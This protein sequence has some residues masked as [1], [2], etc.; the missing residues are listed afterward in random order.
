MAQLKHPRRE[1]SSGIRRCSVLVAACAALFFPTHAAV[2][3][4]A[5]LSRLDK[6]CVAAIASG[7]RNLAKRLGR[8]LLEAT[9]KSPSEAGLTE[10]T[11]VMFDHANRRLPWRLTCVFRANPLGSVPYLAEA[12]DSLDFCDCVALVFDRDM[13]VKARAVIRRVWSASAGK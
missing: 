9:D 8:S 11:V 7:D 10:I 5:D 3:A 6:A 2:A 4:N 1:V 13:L 12:A